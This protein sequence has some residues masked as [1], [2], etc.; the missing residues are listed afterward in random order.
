MSCFNDFFIADDHSPL[1]VIHD[2]KYS[3]F[4]IQ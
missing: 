1:V 4:N 3:I 2:E